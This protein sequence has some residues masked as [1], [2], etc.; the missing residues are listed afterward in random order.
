LLADRRFTS[1]VPSQYPGCTVAEVSDVRVEWR[2]ISRYLWVG[3]SGGNHVGVIEHGHGYVAID[4]R[5]QV[6]AR[7]K[8][9]HDAKQLLNQYAAQHLAM[10][11]TVSAASDDR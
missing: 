3:E 5:G 10:R 8:T 11:P 6:R 7:V 2:Q 9:I 1:A 4:D